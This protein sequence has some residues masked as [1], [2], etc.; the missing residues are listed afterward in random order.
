MK[1]T[2][3][4]EHSSWERSGRREEIDGLSE[5]GPARRDEIVESV[6]EVFGQQFAD[7]LLTRTRPLA[8]R[9][10][11]YKPVEAD[12][13]LATFT[14][15]AEYSDKLARDRYRE[16]TIDVYKDVGRRCQGSL[17]GVA[18]SVSARVTMKA[19]DRRNTAA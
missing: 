12:L 7:V 16:R 14:L 3:N 8:H 4:R 10:S 2:L 17:L 11:R 9:L 6:D 1:T 5:G 15:A 13:C 19:A 18:T